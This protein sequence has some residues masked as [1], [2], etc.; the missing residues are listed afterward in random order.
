[1]KVDRIVSELITYETRA[2]EIENKTEVLLHG[3]IIGQINMLELRL[4][5]MKKFGVGASK[6]EIKHQLDLLTVA[7]GRASNWHKKIFQADV[8]IRKGAA[9]VR[10]IN[11]EELR[12]IF[13]QLQGIGKQDFINFDKNRVE[14]A[15]EAFKKAFNKMKSTLEKAEKKNP[16][17]VRLAISEIIKE[18]SSE[19]A[20]VL[21]FD[22]ALTDNFRS[23]LELGFNITYFYSKIDRII[24]EMDEAEIIF[25]QAS[26]ET[27]RIAKAVS[28]QNFQQTTKDIEALVKI[29][30]RERVV[31]KERTE[32]DEL[33]EKYIEQVRYEIQETMQNLDKLKGHQQL[34]YAEFAGLQLRADYALRTAAKVGSRFG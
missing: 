14:P 28:G 13:T 11:D 27:D 10:R 26:Y 30:E 19:H 2:G 3:K 34:L 22:N 25:N 5:S 15:I 1:M 21:K 31:I 17:I 20:H 32:M 8:V 9:E 16:D 12:Q 33:S 29:I 18:F 4:K 24:K 7:R 23:V 6:G